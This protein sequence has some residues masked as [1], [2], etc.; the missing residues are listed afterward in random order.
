MDLQDR[1]DELDN[2]ITTLDSLIDEIT[3][4][5]YIDQL[6]EIK[7][8]AENELEEVSKDLREEYDREE[9]EMEYQYERSQF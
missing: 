4:R 2:I 3:D 7:W 5:D 8:Q 1:Y 9:Q 6:R